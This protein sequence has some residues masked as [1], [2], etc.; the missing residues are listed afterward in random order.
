MAWDWPDVR[1]DGAAVLLRRVPSTLLTV[2]RIDSNQRVRHIG[3]V[4]IRTS[5]RQT[6]AV[7]LGDQ[8][9]FFM[10]CMS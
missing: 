9:K 8:P 2:A 1:N 6:H 5:G 4:N 10:C 3:N 7:S